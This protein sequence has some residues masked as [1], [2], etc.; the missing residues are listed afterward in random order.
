[1]A[2]RQEPDDGS[3]EARDPENPQE[4]DDG[5]VVRQADERISNGEAVRT[6]RRKTHGMGGERRIRERADPHPRLFLDGELRKFPARLGRN[7]WV[8]F[9]VP[10]RMPVHHG[11]GNWLVRS[12][13]AR[14]DIGDDGRQSGGNS[15]RAHPPG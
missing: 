6:E 1:M 12:R 5:E 7:Q 15:K 3:K 8:V 4:R 9:H 13:R 14:L 10:R 2:S 11:N